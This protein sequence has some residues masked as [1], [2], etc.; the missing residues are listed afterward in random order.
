ME[1]SSMRLNPIMSELH[2]DTTRYL[3]IRPLF[4]H[5]GS[6]LRGKVV[7]FK[8]SVIFV[9]ATELIFADLKI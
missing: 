7:G 2:M 5:E 6:I 3:L 4:E 8:F 9:D 1:V